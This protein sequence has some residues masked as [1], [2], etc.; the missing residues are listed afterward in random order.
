MEHVAPVSWLNFGLL[1]NGISFVYILSP[2]S[3]FVFYLIF[4][5]VL[6]VVLKS[7]IKT[8][9]ILIQIFSPYGRVEDVYLMRDEM[10]QSRG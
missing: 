7:I 2:T 8:A 5:V 6:V 10:K 9:N 1:Y 4:L 3:I